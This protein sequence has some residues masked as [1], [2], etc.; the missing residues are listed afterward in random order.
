MY[1]GDLQET[2][3]DEM[4]RP[5]RFR[6]NVAEREGRLGRWGRFFWGVGERRKTLETGGSWR[7]FGGFQWF[8]R[9]PFTIQCVFIG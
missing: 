4:R 8:S 7:C 6:T 1:L 3:E 2:D 5:S 9:V